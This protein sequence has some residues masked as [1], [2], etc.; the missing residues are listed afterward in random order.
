MLPPTTPPRLPVPGGPGRGSDH[1]SQPRGEDGEQSRI[2]GVRDGRLVVADSGACGHLALAREPAPIDTDHGVERAV[3][4][5]D[6][7]AGEAIESELE[8]LDRRH[9]PGQADDARRPP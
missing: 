6:R 5:G 8:T 2:D 7:V 4:D 9:E 3:G 1:L